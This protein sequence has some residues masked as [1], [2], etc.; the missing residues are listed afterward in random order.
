LG[1][2]HTGRSRQSGEHIWIWESPR[3]T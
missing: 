3:A 1:F 2:T